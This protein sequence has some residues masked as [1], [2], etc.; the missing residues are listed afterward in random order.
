[1]LNNFK[2]GSQSLEFFGSR[3]QS[4]GGNENTIGGHL[5]YCCIQMIER[6]LLTLKTHIDVSSNSIDS[7]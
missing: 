7:H 2:P 3:G 4:K 1:M 5:G 6:S